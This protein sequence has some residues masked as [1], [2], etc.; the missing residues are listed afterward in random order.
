MSLP[1]SI[2]CL[3]DFPV[4]LHDGLTDYIITATIT[5]SATFPGTMMR[6]KKTHL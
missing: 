5:P 4:I 2:E 6:L 1:K 3:F